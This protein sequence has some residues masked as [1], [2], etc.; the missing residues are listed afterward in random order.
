VQHKRLY[1]SNEVKIG[2]ELNERDANFCA[3]S[4][5]KSKIDVQRFPSGKF[6][7]VLNAFR[8]TTCKNA[9]WGTLSS[10]LY[11][12]ISVYNPALIVVIPNENQHA[13]QTLYDSLTRSPFFQIV[14][15]DVH[16]F[17]VQVLLEKE[18]L[19]IIEP[20]VRLSKLGNNSAQDHYIR[21]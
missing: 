14:P 6:V 13:G 17:I 9:C 2:S 11:V 21:V 7:W 20:L 16:N 15:R 5:T 4:E 10:G 18:R 19:P 8:I 3:R 12:Y 1:C